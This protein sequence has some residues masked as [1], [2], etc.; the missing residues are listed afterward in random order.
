MADDIEEDEVFDEEDL[1]EGFDAEDIE[2][3]DILD[4]DVVDADADG[5]VDVK[6]VDLEDE[7]VEEVVVEVET[8][9]A[10]DED[11][12]TLDHDVELAL[13]DR[14]FACWDPGYPQWPELRRRLAAAVPFPMPRTEP[15]LEAGWL[16]EQG[17]YELHIGR[18]SG[19]V[20]HVVP[21]EVSAGPSP[22]IPG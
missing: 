18:S 5:D 3:E 9:I 8:P 21:L 7:D 2:A 10:D 20:A 17:R 19:D 22:V 14:C 6:D 11:D 12:L 16:V 13:D 4:G 15:Q 1:A